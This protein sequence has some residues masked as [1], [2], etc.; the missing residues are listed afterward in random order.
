MKINKP[1]DYGPQTLLI[2][3]Y[4]FIKR[5][6]SLFSKIRFDEFEKVSWWCYKNHFTYFQSY[7]LMILNWIKSILSKLLCLIMFLTTI[8]KSM[9]QENTVRK[10]YWNMFTVPSKDST[11]YYRKFAYKNALSAIDKTEKRLSRKV[12]NF[13]TSFLKVLRLYNLVWYVCDFMISSDFF[14]Y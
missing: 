7:Q 9:N 11:P 5:F 2:H 12:L 10:H 1:R 13:L 14:L 3:V 8:W 6:N 4:S